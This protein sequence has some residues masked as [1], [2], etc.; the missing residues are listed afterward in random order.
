MSSTP[1]SAAPLSPARVAALCDRIWSGRQ[2]PVFAVLDGARDP[3]VVPSLRGLPKW[4]LFSGDLHPDL[5]AAAPY[6][7]ALDRRSEETA[8]LLSRAWGR[9]WGVLLAAP[10]DP[11][12]L[13][14]HLRRFLRVQDPR[15]KTVYFRY[16]DPRVLRVYLP[17]CDV[18]EL[19]VFFG[20]IAR[21]LVE[22]KDPSSYSEHRRAGPDL[23]TDI[24]PW[25]PGA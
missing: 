17:T 24:I 12:T 1:V 13:R 2:D 16:Y 11:E 14:R 25:D 4:C 10:T 18:D 23:H 6:L 3:A 20:P 8:A 5:A 19:R 22:D 21:I 7:A 9:S 15:G